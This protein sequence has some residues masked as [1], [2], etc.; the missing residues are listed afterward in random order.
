MKLIRTFIL[1]A[2]IAGGLGYLTKPSEADVD[3]KISETIAQAIA[4][5]DV[6]AAR[7]PALALVLLT[8]KSN[9]STCAQILKS[10]IET[11]VD[12]RL[13]YTSVD[14]QGFGH[15]ATCYGAFTQFFCPG[16]LQK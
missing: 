16:G 13:V 12:D 8:C 4:S 2:V 5:G 10:G 9:Q 11:R 6:D 15:R 7:D 1:L 14:V 3:A